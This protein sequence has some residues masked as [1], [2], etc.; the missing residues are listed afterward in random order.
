MAER[1]VRGDR[2]GVSRTG[3]L[4]NAFA[5][6]PSSHPGVRENTFWSVHRENPKTARK[7]SLTNPAFPIAE[8]NGRFLLLFAGMSQTDIANRL[9]PGTNAI[10]DWAQNKSKVP[11]RRL[12]DASSS[13]GSGGTGLSTGWL[14]SSGSHIRS[15]GSWACLPLIVVAATRPAAFTAAPS[16]SRP[17]IQIHGMQAPPPFVAARK[18][19]GNGATAP[20]SPR[21]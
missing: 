5:F 13:F 17:I 3:C 20:A 6:P 15:G 8:I 1:A 10:N 4:N 12:A 7:P 2:E 18:L 14:R 16:P 19:P 21:R 9:N 11:W